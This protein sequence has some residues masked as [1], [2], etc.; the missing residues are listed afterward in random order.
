MH[1]DKLY[2]YA[3]TFYLPSVM[4]L[5][6]LSNDVYIKSISEIN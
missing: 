6:D 1:E 3:L 4:Q 2:R 5:W